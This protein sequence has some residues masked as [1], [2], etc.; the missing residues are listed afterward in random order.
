MMRP[1]SPP[2]VAR[3][4]SLLGNSKRFSII[5]ELARGD[6]CVGDL[7]QRVDLSQSALSQHLA[8]LRH[9]GMVETRR[10]AQTIFYSCTD[11]DV[12]RLHAAAAELMS[13]Q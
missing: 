9:A 10:E 3:L 12:L 2:Q 6:I 13:D 4:L 7:S 11:P 1:L 5:S 8:K